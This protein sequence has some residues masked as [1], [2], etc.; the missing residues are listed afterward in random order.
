MNNKSPVK[1]LTIWSGAAS[2]L[3]GITVLI[4]LLLNQAGV[5]AN[6]TEIE[7]IVAG[8]ISVI[9]GLITIYGRYRATTVIKK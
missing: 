4:S 2:S 5:E 9:S 3:G 7:T 1:S 8:S 6:S